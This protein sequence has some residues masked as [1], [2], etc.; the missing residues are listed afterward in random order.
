MKTQDFLFEIGTEEMPPLRLSAFK[1]SLVSSL[2]EGLN[3]AKLAFSTIEGFVTPR[4][5]AVIIRNLAEQQAPQH[6]ERKGPSVESAFDENK[7]PTPALRGFLNSLNV[8]EKD[9]QIQ[10]TP[11]GSFIYYIAQKEG[12]SLHELLPP[13][14]ELALKNLPIP[15]RMKWGAYAHTFVRPV[16][17]VVA[18]YGNKVLPMSFFGHAADRMTYGHRFHAPNPIVLENA[19]TY[20]EALKQAFVLV[21][22]K[23]RKSSILAQ[24]QQ[25]ADNLQASA[26]ISDSVLDEVTGLTEWPVAM[27]AQF[28]EAFLQLPPE[29]PICSMQTHQRYFPLKDKA[30]HL[31][32]TFLVISN[33]Q[34]RDLSIVQQGHARVVRARLSDAL[35]FYQQDSKTSLKSH[36][37]QLDH[38]VFQNQLG[39]IGDKIQRIQCISKQI[40]SL[41]EAN[42][43]FLEQACDLAKCDLLSQMVYEFPELQG[44]MGAYYA[45]RVDKVPTPVATAIAEHLLPRFASDTLP[46]TPEGLVLAIS[47]RIDTLYGIF[48]IGMLPTGT[49]DPYALRRQAIAILRMIVEKSHALSLTALIAA[50]QHA[51][52]PALQDKK[53]AALL[54]GFFKERLK[55]WLQDNDQIPLDISDAVLAVTDEPFHAFCRA[56]ALIAFKKR[57]EA[58]ALAAAHKRVHNILAKTQE[59]SHQSILVQHFELPIEHTLFEKLD[60]LQGSHDHAYLLEQLAS[61][62][63]VVDAFFEEVLVMS[64]NLEVRANRIALL[65]K[66]HGAFCLVADLSYLQS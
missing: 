35:Y 64:P 23:A 31:L 62:Q 34:A 45:E 36:R 42:S 52:P 9:C 15:K 50:A 8:E 55:Y 27:T 6:I 5:L 14:I 48:A 58:S 30:G 21:D 4:R 20:V 28:D 22:E 49:K 32:S 46:Q 59:D 37:P 41:F 12:A 7:N 1:E 63:P 10:E 25:K 47:D 16:H 53:T 26:V 44:T 17:W 65:K 33:T 13:L 39:S 54:L 11:K 61:L 38:I 56:K 60:Q 2:Q 19:G 18:L 57:P 43:V 24:L 3:E 29:V 40:A 51:Y 66:L